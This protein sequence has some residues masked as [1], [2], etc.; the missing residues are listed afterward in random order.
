MTDAKPGAPSASAP[1]E[2]LASREAGASGEAIACFLARATP[3]LAAGALT[4]AEVEAVAHVAP[5]FG[6]HDPEVLLGLAFVA[7][8]PRLGHV[9]LSLEEAPELFEGVAEAP[10][11]WPADRA[12]WHARTAASPLVGEGKP[13]APVPYAVDE[14]EAPRGRLA[15]QRRSAEEA[16]VAAL[17]R[18]RAATRIAP[19]DGTEELLARFF[20]E[21][22][23]GEAARAVRVC[24][25]SSLTV[26]T[27]GPGTG[28]TFSLTRLLAVIAGAATD[29]RPAAIRLAAPTGKAA[30][31]MGE[32]IAE[33]LATLELVAPVRARLAGIR[34]ETLHKLLGVRPDGTVAH[35]ERNPIH[36]DLVVVD[37]ASMVDLALMRVLLRAVPLGA[38]LVLLGDPDQLASVEAGAVL[39]DFVRSAAL[40]PN[41]VHFTKSRRFA[42][43]PSLAACA[44]ALQS[45]QERDDEARD[46]A[47]ATPGASTPQLTLFHEGAE[48][49]RV[50]RAIALL[51]G[52]AHAEADP[53]PKR[54]EWLR[55]A[56]GVG[57]ALDAKQLARIVAPYR[58]GFAARLAALPESPS[59][60]DLAALLA[61]FDDYR[62][63]AV[64]RRG[65]LGVEGLAMTLEREVLGPRRPDETGTI[66]RHGL[67][68][69]VT[70]NAPEAQLTNGDVGLV[71]RLEGALQ[72]VFT[73]A[74]AGVRRVAA[75]RLPSVESAFA[76]TVHKSQGSQFRR[77]ALVMPGRP[78][79]LATRELVY[80]ALTRARET[81]VWV[82]SERELR[83][84]L[85]ARTRRRSTLRAR[86]AH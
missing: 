23:T 81:V 41:R 3:F 45:P 5:R 10:L 52:R 26:V 18:Q 56:K 62:V 12:A 22:P 1:T 64:L 74:A 31:R 38:R 47:S 28:K 61:S 79:P 57:G 14:A 66:L 86:L 30:A 69:L 13:F 25:E 84:A 82:G 29:D 67:P 11:P 34:A 75:A 55:E 50:D 24:A 73:S 19:P 32:A 7:A 44:H 51:T 49:V 48:D 16:H 72:A 35:H 20:A 58:A 54:L 33:G 43:A 60:A 15:T 65:A 21:D 27:G 53:M 2:P 78:S 68:I 40:S 37:E 77:V 70:E 42:L 4:H 36:A 39:G 46:S 83:E 85:L 71:L 9:V 6:E 63:L 80:T 17:V 59:E 76:M 8:A